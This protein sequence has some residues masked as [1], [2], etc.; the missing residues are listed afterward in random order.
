MQTQLSANL[1]SS[2]LGQEA[3]SIL[4]TCVHCGFCLPACP[5]YRI[6]GNELDSPRGRIY[7]MK[8]L[9]EGAA[10][11]QKTQLHLDRCL[12]CLACEAAC[13]SGVQYGRLVD[14]GRALTEQAVPRDALDTARRHLLAKIL[15]RPKIF[16]ALLQLG[17]L[18]RPILPAVMKQK[19]PLPRTRGAWPAP[20]H[21]RKM[22][23]L[24]GCVQPS[25]APDINAAAARVLDRLGISLLVAEKAG[26]CGALS[27]HL[28]RHEEAKD[29]MRRNIDAWWPYLEQGVEAIVMT[30]SGC[31]SMV[32][33]YAH[34]LREDAAYAAKAQQLSAIT[35]DLSE[36]VF[37]EKDRLPDLF[38]EVTA[39]PKLAYHPPCTLQHDQKITGVI[40]Q[41]LLL[42]G[43]D[44]TPVRDSDICCGSAGTYS[45]LQKPLAQTLLKNKIA[46]LSAG[47]PQQ[48]VTANIGCLMH[49][50][51]GTALAVKHW[52]EAVDERI[53]A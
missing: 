17:Q 21:S 19:I 48:I 9:M 51:S 20:R 36:I 26:C 34:A 28:N 2:G 47:G 41:L 7:L 32:K 22:L 33:D 14:I 30:A 46:A 27:F 37:K 49:I 43:Y 24:E 12:T 18:F 44:L 23:V 5:T 53:A 35:F 39:K 42:A 8:Q 13:P 31:G 3:E 10:V 4:R 40:E 38:P 45:I 1:K 16:S 25:L 50:Q 52:I 11:T 15:S 6:L 29:H